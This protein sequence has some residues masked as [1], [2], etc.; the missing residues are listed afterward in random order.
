MSN[1]HAVTKEFEKQ[2]CLYT[3]APFAVAV[4]SCTSLHEV[5]K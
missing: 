3:G 2:L 4:N 1:P 5:F